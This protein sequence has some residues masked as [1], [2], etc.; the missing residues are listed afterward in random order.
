MKETVAQDLSSNR[1][2]R[3]NSKIITA[4]SRTALTFRVVFC[5]L[6]SQ[7][8]ITSCY[9]N[10][11]TRPHRLLLLLVNSPSMSPK[12]APSRGWVFGPPSNTSN[13]FD[14]HEFTCTS[15]SV[16]PFC[17]VYTRSQQ[18]QTHRQIRPRYMCSNTP[19][20]YALQL[21]LIMIVEIIIK[22]HLSHTNPRDALSR[23]LCCT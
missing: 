8:S 9:V 4:V 18:T 6:C 7:S 12:S 2:Y 14:S 15:R 21:G 3:I 5:L 22:S 19:H 1:N 23:P 10:G 16:R 11:N 20:C 13:T 17:V